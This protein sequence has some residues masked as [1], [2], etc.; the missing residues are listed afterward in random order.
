MERA[1]GMATD[2]LVCRLGVDREL[3]YGKDPLHRL[4]HSPDVRDDEGDVVSVSKEEEA[5]FLREAA[6]VLIR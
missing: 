4:E 6:K 5:M 3:D 2:F 1:M